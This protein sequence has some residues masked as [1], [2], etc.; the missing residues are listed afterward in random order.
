MHVYG[1][2][3]VVL[4]VYPVPPHCPQCATPV[5]PGEVTVVVVPGLDGVVVGDVPDEASC[6]FTNVKA[7]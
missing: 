6:A 3:Q 4:P 7:C 5:D 2:A 1:L